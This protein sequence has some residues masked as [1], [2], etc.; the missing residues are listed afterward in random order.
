MQS[1]AIFRVCA[2]VIQS[3]PKSIILESTWIETE[4]YLDMLQVI[5]RVCVEMCYLI[6]WNLTEKA[7]YE[8]LINICVEK[9]VIQ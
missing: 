5:K 6:R 9:S 3:L 2:H 7:F 1:T 8:I 4:H